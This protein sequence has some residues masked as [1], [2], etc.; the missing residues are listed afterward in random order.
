[1][2]WP[3]LTHYEYECL[4]G[5][6]PEASFS[7][8]LPWAVRAVKAECWPNEPATEAQ[9]SVARAAYAAAV[10]A[11]LATGGTHGADAGGSFSIGG[12]SESAGDGGGRAAIRQA[13]AEA[14]AGSGLMCRVML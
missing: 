9:E 3:G 1:M 4:G 8:A 5:T 11:D 7:A 6:A 12:Y 14:L 13:I 2:A 10:E